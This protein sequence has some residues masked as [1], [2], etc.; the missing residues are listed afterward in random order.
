MNTNKLKSNNSPNKTLSSQ[1]KNVAGAAIEK[2]KEVAEGIKAAGNKITN[3]AQTGIGAV[4]KKVSNVAGSEQITGPITKWTAMTQEF[5]TA[6]SAISKFVGFF[7]CLLLFIILFQI[8]MSFMQSLFGASYNPYII[9][10]MVASDVLTVV[11]SNPNVSGSVPIY[12]SVDENQGLE[13]SWNVWFMVSDAKTGITN[14]R[15]F[16]K[17]LINQD[18]LIYKP[19]EYDESEYLNV[20]PGLFISS[21]VDTNSINLTLIMNTFDNSNNTIEKI[22][23]PNIPIQKWI[24]CTIRV[25]GKSVDIYINGLLKQRKNLINLPRQN[26]YDTYIGEDA[27]MKGYVS[28]L[29]YYGY[30]IG[31][32]EV[33]SLFASGPSLKM[34]TTTTMPAS[35]DYLSMN[36]YT[37]STYSS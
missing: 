11:S 9:N 17:G 1:A 16:S 10:G 18:N 19:L 20:S 22:I 14:N 5:L 37:T 31:Y 27:G 33:Q 29:R 15:I 28:S 4:Q 23:I 13:F 6:N 3:A 25:Q 7:L 26:Y 36:W 32:D 24:C 34:I 21:S 12:R 30:A 2:T 8:G 35:S